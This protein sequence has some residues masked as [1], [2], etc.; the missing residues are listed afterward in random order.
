VPQRPVHRVAYPQGSVLESEQIVG[1][2]QPAR[3]YRK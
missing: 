1:R 2:A 3:E